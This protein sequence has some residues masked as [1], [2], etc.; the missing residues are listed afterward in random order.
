MH[1]YIPEQRLEGFSAEVDDKTAVRVTASLERDCQ[2][3]L[4]V[5]GSRTERDGIAC[6][7]AFDEAHSLTSPR[8]RPD[9]DRSKSPYH[10]L[11]TVLTHIYDAPIFFVFLSTNSSLLR[12]TPTKARTNGNYFFPPFTELPFDIYSKDYLS[13]HKPLTLEKMCTTEAMTVFGRSL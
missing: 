4:Q 7:V 9:N 11:E 6:M 10:N 2:L 1:P 8:T 3:F 13:S 12:F 5:I